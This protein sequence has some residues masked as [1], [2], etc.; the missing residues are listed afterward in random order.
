[1]DFFAAP[2]T[3]A[4][5]KTKLLIFYFAIAVA[6]LIIAVYFAS[7]AGF[8]RRAGAS[9]PQL[10]RTAAVSRFGI[11]NSSSASPSACWRSF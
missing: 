1:M 7:L 8:H 10:R 4:R 2:G 9:P 3:R 11:R 6:A 5:K